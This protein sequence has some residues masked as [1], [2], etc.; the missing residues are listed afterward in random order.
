[1]M[2]YNLKDC[3]G[4]PNVNYV[5]V[6][7]RPGLQEFLKEVHKFANL[8][9]FTAGLEGSIF[10]RLFI[11]PAILFLYILLPYTILDFS[12]IMQGHL[13]TG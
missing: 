9:L 7:E 1:M 5:T 11:F 6:F 3:N 4:K 13:S 2:F 12:Q 8:I 10:I